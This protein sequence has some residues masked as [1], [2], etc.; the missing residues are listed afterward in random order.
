MT[1]TSISSP[2]SKVPGLATL[3]G[4]A[5]PV[6]ISRASQVVVGL[7]DAVMVAHLGETS[8][9]ATTTGAMNAFTLFIFPMGVVF[10]V[11][12]YA[13]Q[14][15]GKGDRPGA[16]RYGVYGLLVGLLTQ[17]AAVASLPLVAPAMNLFSYNPEVRSLIADY[18]HIRLLA[19]GMVVGI[20]ALGNY[21]GGLGNTRLPML[22]N[23]LA[24][25]LNVFGNWLLIDGH[26]GLPAMGVRGAALASVLATLV[27]LLLL[28]WCFARDARPF[29]AWWPLL[30]RRELLRMLRFGVP[31]GL[32]WLL[33][34][35]AFSFFI[36]V[37]VAGLGTTVLAALMAVMQIN[38][39]SFMPAFAVASAG[40][41]LSGQAIG[42]DQ[43]DHVPT[44]AKL[45]LKVNVIWQGLVS[46]VYLAVPALLFAPFAPNAAEGAVLARTG[47]HLLMLSAT[48]QL[49]DA[50]AT[51]MSEILRSAGDTTFTLWARVLLA[52]LVFV[53]G[54]YLTTRYAGW[55]ESGAVFWLASY[56]AL[57][58]GV[59]IL[60]FARG[61]WRR[62]QITE[63]AVS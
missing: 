58:A 6:V 1:S 45:T 23:L 8:L 27:G 31:A 2:A 54:A 29:G 30:R 25:G 9:A 3:L 53:P 37:V 36:N 5:W 26:W 16:V 17:L 10:I 50:T 41:I 40:A 42:A 56:L 51:T 61:A 44:I 18:I 15:F 32:N 14:L 57:L 52:W 49:F 12:S 46:I 34:F 13:S 19:A 55:S 39:F 48:W 20:E 38:S 43:K 60:R 33:E 35:L 21:Y 62:I 24:M 59:L 11:S 4:L 47:T 7:S 28:L 63:P 22:A